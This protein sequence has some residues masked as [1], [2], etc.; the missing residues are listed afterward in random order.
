M[1][2]H[3]RFIYSFLTMFGHVQLL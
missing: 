2:G 1:A 3:V